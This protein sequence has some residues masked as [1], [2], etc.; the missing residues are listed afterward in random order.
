M[1]GV[2][3][4]EPDSLSQVPCRGLRSRRFSASDKGF[5]LIE[6]LVAISILA[7]SL[8][9]ILQL[10][11]GA[12]KSSRISDEYTT[13]IFYAREKMEEILLRDALTSGEQ[14]GEFDQAYRWRAQIVRMEQTGE[15]ASKLPID[16]F[17]ITVD[18]SWDRDSA[19]QGKHFQLSTLKVVEKQ[20]R[21]EPEAVESEEA[22]D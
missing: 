5:T 2:M 10:F 19:G 15:A 3:K 14:E 17:Q 7:I 9:V 18:V 6:I 1:W 22:K 11:S 4:L 8:V 21:E 13:G 20:G 16:M 12:L